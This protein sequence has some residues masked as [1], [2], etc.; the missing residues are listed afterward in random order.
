[1]EKGSEEGL[2]MKECEICGSVCKRMA[3]GHY[4]CVSCGNIFFAEENIKKNQ[5]MPTFSN[6]DQGVSVFDNCI[7]GVAEIRWQEGDSVFSG[8]GYLISSK[9]YVVTAAHVLFGHGGKM[10]DFCTVKLA[11]QEVKGKVF[12]LGTRNQEEYCGLN[13]LAVIRLESIP[14]RAKVLKFADYGDVRTGEKVYVIGNSLGLGTCITSGIVSDRQ[15]RGMLM[16]DCPV[17]C[18]N[19]GGPIFNDQGLIIGTMIGSQL[20][21]G[22]E[23]TAEG[24]NYAIPSNVVIQFIKKANIIV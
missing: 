11:N 4:R 1:M 12:A 22:S 14:F 9:G 3:D 24:M 18:G 23:I 6:R 10:C 13:D 20:L 7:D 17:N 15:R 8:S 16:T 21:E 2:G 19:S 5:E